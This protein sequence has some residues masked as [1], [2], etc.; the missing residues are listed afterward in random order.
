MKKINPVYIKFMILISMILLIIL[1]PTIIQA[2][3]T[4]LE[5]EN[6]SVYYENDELQATE[7]IGDFDNGILFICER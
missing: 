7:I 6:V 3:E 4:C 2:Q 1:I 5:F